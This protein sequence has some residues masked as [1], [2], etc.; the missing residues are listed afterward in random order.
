MKIG[1]RNCDSWFARANACDVLTLAVRMEQGAARTYAS[2]ARKAE[3]PATRAK[4]RY[5]AAEEREHGRVLGKAR[6]N[7]TRPPHAHNLLASVAEA[8]G[9]ADGDSPQAVLRQAIRS[10]KEAEALYR[11]CA[12]RCKRAAP[13]RMFERLAGQE[14]GHAVALEAELRTLSGAFAWSSIEGA[15]P[16][17]EDFWL[18]DG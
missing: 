17:E 5:L 2:L 8:G 15:V 16:E 18:G 6:R 1:R 13:K 10:E 3:H 7:L 9:V 4:F 12:A 14:A 11:A